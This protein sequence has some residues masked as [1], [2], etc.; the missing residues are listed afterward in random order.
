NN[1]F[2]NNHAYGLVVYSKGMIT[3]NNITA[4]G[5]Q[6][7]GGLYADNS[8]SPA[9]KGITL[10]GTN[11]MSWNSNDGL[12]VSSAGT[13]TLKNVT[14]NNNQYFGGAVY[15]DNPGATGTIVLSGNN[16]F[17]YNASEGL[18]IASFHAMTINNITANFNGGYGVDLDNCQYDNAITFA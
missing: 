6:N 5:S 13:I 10:N 11:E 8:S 15:N 12:Q 16:S 1:F 2:N 3:L 18:N 4:D 17:S 7:F 14:A 9:H